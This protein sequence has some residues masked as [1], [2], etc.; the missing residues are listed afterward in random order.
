[1][2]QE[3]GKK[4]DQ[5]GMDQ[6]VTINKIGKTTSTRTNWTRINYPNTTEIVGSNRLEIN[7]HIDNNL[8]WKMIYCILSQNE[9]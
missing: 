3:H 7:N 5:K 2:C 9:Y 4:E 1:M 8:L 6:E